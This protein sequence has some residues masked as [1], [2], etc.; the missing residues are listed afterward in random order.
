MS[1]VITRKA[2]MQAHEGRDYYM[3]LIEI[4]VQELEHVDGEL[5]DDVWPS[6]LPRIDGAFVLY[7][8]SDRSSFIHTEELIRKYFDSITARVLLTYKCCY[9]WVLY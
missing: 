7:D 9:R 8:A 5:H 6:A 3:T 2:C 4:S 1:S